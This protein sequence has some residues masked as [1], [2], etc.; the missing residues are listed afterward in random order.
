MKFSRLAFI[1]F[2]AIAADNEGLRALFL[3][4]HGLMALLLIL[5][6]VCHGIERGRTAF[7][8][9]GSQMKA[10]GPAQL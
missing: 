2:S 6:I 4:L 7:I 9:D 1:P 10:P 5:L 3:E 8:D